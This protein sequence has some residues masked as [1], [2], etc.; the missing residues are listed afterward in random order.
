[1]NHTN[2]SGSELRTGGHCDTII[3]RF[4]IEAE[5]VDKRSVSHSTAIFE[6]S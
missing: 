3:T 1:M 6:F 5:S 4:V 2:H